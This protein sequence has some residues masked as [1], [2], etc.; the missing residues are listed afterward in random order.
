MQHRHRARWR[1][2]PRWCCSARPRHTPANQNARATGA[3]SAARGGCCRG[4]RRRGGR[5]RPPPGHRVATRQ[6]PAP[7]GQS[8]RRP[9]PGWWAGARPCPACAYQRQ[10]RCGA[11]QNR[12]RERSGNAQERRRRRTGPV[13]SLWNLRAAHC[14]ASLLG[15]GPARAHWKTSVLRTA[16]RACLGAARRALMRVPPLEKVATPAGPASRVR[17]RS[18]CRWGCQKSPPGRRPRS[19]RCS[20]PVRIPADPRPR[21]NSPA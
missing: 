5:A 16:V 6:W 12:K 2:V 17:C 14:G 15:S 13:R 8:A 3:Q 10:R 20:R 7:P 11:A 19:T 21:P 9:R 18:A 1:P 4:S